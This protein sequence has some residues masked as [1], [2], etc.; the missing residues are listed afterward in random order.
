MREIEIEYCTEKNVRIL[1]GCVRNSRYER[2]TSRVFGSVPFPVEEA[3]VS[4]MGPAKDVD[5][6]MELIRGF[7]IISHITPF[8]IRGLR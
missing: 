5:T 3:K 6:Y 4:A 1:C 2:T 8:A 7:R